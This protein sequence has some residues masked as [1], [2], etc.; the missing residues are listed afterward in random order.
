MIPGP[1]D[2]LSF[3]HLNNFINAIITSQY[4]AVKL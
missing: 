2:I 1:K 4:M 3:E